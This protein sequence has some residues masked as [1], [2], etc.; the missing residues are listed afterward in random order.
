MAYIES[1]RVAAPILCLVGIAAALVG[2]VM[3]VWRQVERT[4]PQLHDRFRQ[5]SVLSDVLKIL[6]SR[7]DFDCVLLRF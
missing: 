1:K 4:A 5:K 2:C 6:S 7:F 3:A